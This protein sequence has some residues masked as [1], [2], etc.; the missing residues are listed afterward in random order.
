MLLFTASD[1]RAQE[2]V[3]VKDS[4]GQCTIVVPAKQETDLRE[5]T[6][7]LAYHLEKMSGASIPI[8]SDPGDARGVPIYIGAKPDGINLPVDLA[9]ESRFWPDGYLIMADGEKV[10]LAAPRIEGIRNAVYGLLEDHLGCHWFAPGEIGEHIPNSTTVKLNLAGGP[11]D[12]HAG[13]ITN[14][15]SRTGQCVKDGGLSRIWVA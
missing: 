9:D 4:Q 11:S 12:S 1:V 14:L 5:V 13:V 6:D 7:D 10:I 8:V 2:T 3:L 15:G